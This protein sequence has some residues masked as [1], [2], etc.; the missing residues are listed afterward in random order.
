MTTNTLTTENAIL[1]VEAIKSFKDNDINGAIHKI[2]P[3][4][5]GSNDFFTPLFRHF[6]AMPEETHDQG[7]EYI[8]CIDTWLKDT[9]AVPAIELAHKCDCCGKPIPPST[10]TYD[11]MLS[12]TVYDADSE[13]RHTLEDPHKED[14][15]PNFTYITIGICCLDRLKTNW[16]AFTT[17][18]L[19]KAA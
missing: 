4:I 8:R 16:A 17:S 3:T 14:F 18:L 13:I 19:I 10:H 15:D 2:L 5:D 9:H 7:I 12:V 6:K 11:I 1:L